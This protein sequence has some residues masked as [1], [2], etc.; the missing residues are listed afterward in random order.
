MSGLFNKK[1]HEIHLISSIY[2]SEFN[3]QKMELHKSVLEPN[4]MASERGKLELLPVLD[5]LGLV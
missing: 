2:L 3:K 1:I 5:K 4:T